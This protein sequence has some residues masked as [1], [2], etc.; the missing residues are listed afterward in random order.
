MLTTLAIAELPNVEPVEPFRAIEAKF[1]SSPNIPAAG[2]TRF[3]FN[4]V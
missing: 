4:I 3:A 1:E 2:A